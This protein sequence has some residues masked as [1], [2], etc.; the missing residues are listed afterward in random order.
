MRYEP[1][2]RYIA[3]IYPGRL[4]D[5]YRDYGPSRECSGPNA[6]RRS[7]YHL[8]PVARGTKPY[9]IE[10][11][12][13][14]QNIQDFVR[15]QGHGNKGKAYQAAPVPVEEIIADILLQWTGGLFNVPPGAKPGIIEIFPTKADLNLCESKGRNAVT[16]RLNMMPVPAMAELNEMMTMQTA[17]FEFFFNEGE[18]IQRGDTEARELWKYITEPMR[19]AAEWLNR[20]RPWSNPSMRSEDVPC[21]WCRTLIDPLSI[22]CAHCGRQVT[23]A[24]AHLAALDGSVEG[25]E[26]GTESVDVQP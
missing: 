11:M 12:D 20:P 18:K 15:T 24:P 9:V 6:I 23:A 21:P 19:L 4:G 1:D 13:C 16:G 22:V 25:V 8:E 10:V 3:S 26:A 7:C 17:Y 5:I 14:F 2:R